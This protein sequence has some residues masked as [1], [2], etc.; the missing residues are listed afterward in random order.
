MDHNT[1]ERRH[2]KILNPFTVALINVITIIFLSFII[3]FQKLNNTKWIMLF[4]T[5]ENNDTKLF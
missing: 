3:I 2:L 5:S 4:N 1:D